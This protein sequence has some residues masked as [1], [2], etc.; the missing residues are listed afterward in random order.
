MIILTGK[1]FR[2]VDHQKCFCG[3]FV[4]LFVFSRKTVAFL[5]FVSVLAEKLTF[6]GRFYF[7][8]ENGKFI[9]GRSVL[10]YHQT[11]SP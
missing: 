5:V 1:P 9:F 4:S 10:A 3:V 2:T 7:S 6:F 11:F 8:A